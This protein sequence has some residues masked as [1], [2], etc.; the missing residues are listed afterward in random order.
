[1]KLTQPLFCASYLGTTSGMGFVA[2]Q[3]VAEKGGEVVCL[4]RASQ[5]AIDATQKLKEAVPNGTFVDVVCDLQDFE[6]VNKAAE[7]VKSKYKTIY[8][9]AFSAEFL[10]QS[11]MPATKDGCDN[12]MQTNHL[13]HF[14]LCAKLYPLVEAYTQANGDARIVLHSSEARNMATHGLE[15]KYFEKNGGKDILGDDGKSMFV[16]GGRTKR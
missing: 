14:I 1:M 9:L 10:T 6:S 2:A 15:R 7:E 3:T 11:T 8:C 12:Q 13:S 5:R 16:G 4:N